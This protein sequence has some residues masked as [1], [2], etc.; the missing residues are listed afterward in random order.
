MEHFQCYD[1]SLFVL[2]QIQET[3]RQGRNCR[4]LFFGRQV[5]D[6]VGGKYILHSVLL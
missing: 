4:N 1:K 3:E 5:Y 2:V 6:V